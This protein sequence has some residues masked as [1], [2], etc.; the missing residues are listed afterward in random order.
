MKLRLSEN[1]IR[2]RLRRSE[3]DRL[4]EA[5][6]LEESVRLGPGENGSLSYALQ[7]HS[8]GPEIQVSY[9]EGR[10]IIGIPQQMAENWIKTEE[11]GIGGEIPIG[12]GEFLSVL[13]EKDFPC[14]RSDPAEDTK[15][16]FGELKQNADC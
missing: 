8:S 12:E 5:G 11:V 15:D 3:V 13:I 10:M 4:A 7:S 2:L 9:A 6:A 1:S 16:L 14:K